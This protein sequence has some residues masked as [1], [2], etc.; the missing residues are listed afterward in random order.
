M[1]L[2]KSRAWE[3]IADKWTG[4]GNL[5]NGKRSYIKAALSGGNYFYKVKGVKRKIHTQEYYICRFINLFYL[6]TKQM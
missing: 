5:V 6:E 1:L 3:K 2:K 4:V